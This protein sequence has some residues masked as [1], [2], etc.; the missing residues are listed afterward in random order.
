MTDEDEIPPRW[1]TRASIEKLSVMFSLR[2]DPYMQ[3]WDIEAADPGIVDKLVDAY[4]DPSL[5]EDDRFALMCLILGSL[6]AA[7]HE[8]RDISVWWSRV[9]KILTEN[10]QVHAYT[11]A[12][13][14]CGE[15]P[16]PDH[17]FLITPEIRNMRREAKP[18]LTIP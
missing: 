8:G 15:D 9:A 2:T 1:Q 4:S 18:G 5:T 16:D 10:T 12:Y 3:D 17:Q 7:K 14:A 13:W 11:M 6:N